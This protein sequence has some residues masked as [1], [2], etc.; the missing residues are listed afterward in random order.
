MNAGLFE[1]LGL[2]CQGID[3][4]YGGDSPMANYVLY[5]RTQY[6]VIKRNEHAAFKWNEPLDPYIYEEAL[7]GWPESKVFWD[8]KVGYSIG[9]APINSLFVDYLKIENDP[10]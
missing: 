6:G 5:I 7:V 9:I 3:K 2:G 1:L 4:F 10:I 8:K